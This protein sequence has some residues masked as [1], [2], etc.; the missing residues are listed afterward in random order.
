MQYEV[1]CKQCGRSFTLSLDKGSKTRCKCPYCAKEL[2]VVT[3]YSFAGEVDAR[4]WA[5][6]QA[7]QEVP[8]QP[9]VD[10]LGTFQEPLII[11]KPEKRSLRLKVIIVFVILMVAILLCNTLLYILFSAISK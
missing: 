11:G 7:F 10:N 4:K 6:G 8:V 1:V 3:P 9:L 5:G 2:I